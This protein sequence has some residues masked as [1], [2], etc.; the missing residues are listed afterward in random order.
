MAIA[1]GTTTS[2]R[3]L[4]NDPPPIGPSRVAGG[5]LGVL[6]TATTAEPARGAQGSTAAAVADLAHAYIDNRGLGRPTDVA[7][8]HTGVLPPAWLLPIAVVRPD[9]SNLDDETLELAASA[10]VAEH[11][12]PSCVTYVRMAAYLLAGHP[13]HD[14]IELATGTSYDPKERDFPQLTREPAHDALLVATWVLTV[15][16]AI[17]A[18]SSHAPPEVAA[19]AAGL[20]GLHIGI[21]GIPISWHR[22]LAATG[23]CIDLAYGLLRARRTAPARSIENPERTG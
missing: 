7:K 10:A 3:P 12:L 18:F 19:A 1:T 13:A 17:A 23:V 5:L 14:A 16:G 6:A 22:H 2:V 8:R 11:S 21:D 4:A 20:V 9:A 15:P